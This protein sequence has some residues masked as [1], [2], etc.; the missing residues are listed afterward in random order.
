MKNVEKKQK[1]Q[2]MENVKIEKWSKMIKF[3]ILKNFVEKNPKMFDDYEC[4]SVSCALCYFEWKMA[5]EWSQL[6]CA[7]PCIQITFKITCVYLIVLKTVNSVHASGVA[8]QALR[9]HESHRPE[10]DSSHKKK[11][12]TVHKQVLLRTKLQPLSHRKFDP[13]KHTTQIPTG[14][15][16]SPS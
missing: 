10:P 11:L 14:L 8:S 6:Q 2:K 12:T 7:S 3:S 9:L 1:Q 15:S 13:L 16:K 5:E 4:E